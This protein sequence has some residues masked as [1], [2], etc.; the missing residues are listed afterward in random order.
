M[1]TN[2]QTN[3]Q[4]SVKKQN[5]ANN[6]KPS[7]LEKS[8]PFLINRKELTGLTTQPTKELEGTS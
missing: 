5:E 1:E 7:A 8:D 3:K 2:K 6:V 4:K